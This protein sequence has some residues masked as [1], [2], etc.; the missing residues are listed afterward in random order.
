MIE[1]LLKYQEADEKLHKIETELSESDVR[2]KAVAAKKYLAGAPESINKLDVKA[3]E[4]Y[5]AYEGML[6]KLTA[7]K[8]QESEFE[9]AV[10]DAEDENAVNYLIKKTEELLAK[11][12]SVSADCA[13]IQSD[14]QAVLKDYATVANTTKSATAQYNENGKLY[15]EL[16]AQKQPEMDAIKSEL[17]KLKGK[18]DPALMAK[19]LEKREKKMFPIVYAVRGEFCGACNMQLNMADLSK[20]KNGEIIE[21][22]QCGRLIYKG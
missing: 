14:I 11:I 12:K 8:D 19:Y 1:E 9:N 16:K 18:V 10:S 13:K 15:N 7:L 2:K 6:N 17:E 20:L 5:S 22:D 4:L 3:A 21:C